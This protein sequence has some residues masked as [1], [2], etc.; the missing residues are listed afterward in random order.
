MSTAT[1]V[2]IAD[3]MQAYAKEAEHL[4]RDQI[5]ELLDYSEA[6]LRH[7]DLLIAGRLQDGIISP[8]SLTSQEESELWMFCKR[9]GGY[10]GE[11]IIRN[12]G[13]AWLTK[14]QSEGR[15]SVHLSIQGGIE[16]QPPNSVWR[17][18]T[19]PNRGSVVGLYETLLSALSLAA[20]KFEIVN[21]IKQVEMRPLSSRPNPSLERT[22]EG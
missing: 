21:G 14:Q 10:L 19:E 7:V 3:V 12:L 2:T 11:V 17:C 6:S 15:F 5:G 13:G 16:A 18:L 20:G 1:P 8:D 22:R 9:I 4:A